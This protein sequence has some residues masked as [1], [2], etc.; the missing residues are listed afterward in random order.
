MYWLLTR[1]CVKAWEIEIVT[2]RHRVELVSFVCLSVLQLC[3]EL[4]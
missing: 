3:F 4:L 2:M 1:F